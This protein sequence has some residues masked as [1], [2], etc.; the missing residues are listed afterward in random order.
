MTMR[1]I[2]SG[3]YEIDKRVRVNGNPI[4][5]GVIYQLVTSIRKNLQK[6]LYVGI[7]EQID[8]RNTQQQVQKCCEY[9]TTG[10]TVSY[11]PSHPLNPIFPSDLYEFPSYY[12]S[13]FLQYI[14]SSTEY[15]G[16]PS[17]CPVQLHRKEKSKII[18]KKSTS[19]V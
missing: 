7:K 12:M 4:H 9:N 1:E 3:S 14:L 5:I 13:T 11:P 16:P 19:S 2:E 8:L 10:A 15:M 6:Y 18:L 17:F